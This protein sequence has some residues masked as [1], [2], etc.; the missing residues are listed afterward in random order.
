[1]REGGL[2]VGEGRAVLREGAEKVPAPGREG[3][4]ERFGMN[5]R[6]WWAYSCRDFFPRKMGAEPE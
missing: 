6:W 2:Q 1:L 4:S 3:V 5:R